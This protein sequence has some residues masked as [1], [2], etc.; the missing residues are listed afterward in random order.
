MR[1]YSD[2][3]ADVHHKQ[4]EEEVLE[5]F[6]G[7]KFQK[8][9]LENFQTFDFEGLKGRLLSS[10]YSPEV[11]HPK[12]APMLAELERIFSTHQVNSRVTIAYDTRLYYGHL[13]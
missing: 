11:G 8:R 13:R 10:S 3:Y 1:K 2:D 4:F 9:T 7:G 6:F 5:H 12:H